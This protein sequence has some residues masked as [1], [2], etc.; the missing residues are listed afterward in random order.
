M[1]S[2]VDYDRNT[3]TVTNLD[4]LTGGLGCNLLLVVDSPYEDEYVAIRWLRKMPKTTQQCE[5]IMRV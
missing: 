5:H 3:M 2:I 1:R 4:Q